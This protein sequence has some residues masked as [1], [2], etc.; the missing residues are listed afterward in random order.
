MTLGRITTAAFLMTF[1]FCAS[2]SAHDMWGT[3]EKAEVGQP[4][5]AVVGYG[6]EFPK[7]EAIPADE[8]GLFKPVRVVGP[9]GEL[10]MKPGPENYKAVSQ[11]ELVKGSYLVIAD[12][13]P[14]FWTKTPDGWSQKPRSEEPQALSCG[15]FIENAKGIVN[16]GG[17]T[18]TGVISQPVGLPIEIVP[19]ANPATVKPGQRLQLKVLFDGK[20]LAGAKVEGRFAGFDK[21]A[22]AGAKAFAD[23]TGKDGVVNFVPLKSGDWLVTVRNERPFPEAGK[24][25]TEDFGTSLFFA[26]AD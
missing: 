12:V 22:S 20:P 2:A 3:A 25:D 13:N 14:V 9:N 10:T 23:T 4:I 15:L 16:V 7:W 24:C 1:L 19:L 5:T 26:I 18:D 21:E 8:I 6:H 17:A 11:E